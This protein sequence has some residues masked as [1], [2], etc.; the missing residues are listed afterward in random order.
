MEQSGELPES[1]DSRF[2][3]T[4]VDELAWRIRCAFFVDAWDIGQSPVLF[5]IADSLGLPGDAIR[6]RVTNGAAMAALS[7]DIDLKT[8]YQLEGSP[9]VVMNNGRQKLYGNVGYRVLEANV[10]ELMNNSAEKQASWC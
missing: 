5:D 6:E 1:L 4:L 8:R 7:D 3:R 2:G 10:V 9:T